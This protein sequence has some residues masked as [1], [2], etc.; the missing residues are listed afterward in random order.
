V[1][2]EANF[3]VD[4]DHY[5]KYTSAVKWNANR[6]HPCYLQ[7][8]TLPLQLQVLTHF[9]SPFKPLGLVH[10]HNSII[11][12]DALK[13]E[14][15]SLLIARFGNIMEHDKGVIAEVVLEAWQDE[16]RVY[17]AICTFLERRSLPKTLSLA[18]ADHLP[19]VDVSEINE[20]VAHSTLS[21]PSNSGRHYASLSGDYNPI[22]LTAL[23]ARMLGFRQAIAHG[24]F[25]L[26]RVLSIV[27]KQQSDN[28]PSQ[29]CVTVHCDFNKPIFLPGE[30]EVFLDSTVEPLIASLCDAKDTSIRHL[31][32]SYACGQAA[33]F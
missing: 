10:L 2:R 17:Q 9:N 30:T 27:E 22:H 28:Q 12:S 1:L 4:L 24:M 7:M 8:V 16:Q 26:A 3:A 29:A 18:C 32:V 13:L 25:S 31:V 19:L 6:F 15:S 21:Y 5:V 23:T 11:Q 33:G 14:Q 20:H